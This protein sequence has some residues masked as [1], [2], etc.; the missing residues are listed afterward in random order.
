MHGHPTLKIL[1]IFTEAMLNDNNRRMLMASPHRLVEIKL[2][3]SAQAKNRHS[4]LEAY[5]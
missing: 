3:P 1:D 2:N 5:N 4:T